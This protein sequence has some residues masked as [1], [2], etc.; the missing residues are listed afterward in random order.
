MIN[1]IIAKKLLVVWQY[2]TQY[3]GG[4]NENEPFSDKITLYSTVMSVKR[5]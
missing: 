5:E 2:I 4:I 3:T 1:K